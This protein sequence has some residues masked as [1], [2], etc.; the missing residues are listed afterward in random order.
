MSD[1]SKLGAM[2]FLAGPGLQVLSHIAKPALNPFVT[3]ATVQM[4]VK[5]GL[6]PASTVGF[7]VFAVLLIKRGDI[8]IGSPFVVLARKLLDKL[9]GTKEYA[10]E[11][12]Y[13]CAEAATFTE[14][15]QATHELR[16]NGEAESISAGDIQYACANRYRNIYAMFSGGTHL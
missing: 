12:L 5:Y 15:L 3:I 7:A 11:V 10:G 8:R 16:V 2:H 4:T 9:D 6:S 14:P 1:Y 13:I